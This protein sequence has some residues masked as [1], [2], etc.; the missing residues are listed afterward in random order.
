MP[1]TIGAD[2]SW[3]AMYSVDGRDLADGNTADWPPVQVTIT[4]TSGAPIS[5][6][7]P[8]EDKTMC[9]QVSHGC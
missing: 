8:F 6:R 2:G 5:Y 7:I 4:R 3:M 1:A 9:N